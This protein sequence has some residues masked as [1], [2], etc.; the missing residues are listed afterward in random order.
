MID[1]EVEDLQYMFPEFEPLSQRVPVQDVFI[2]MNQTAVKEAVAD[3]AIA[4]QRYEHYLLFLDEVEE[5]KPY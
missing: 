2:A 3:G 5:N 1:I 4:R